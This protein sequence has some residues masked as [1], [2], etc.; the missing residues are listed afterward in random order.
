LRSGAGDESE[1]QLKIMENLVEKYSSFRPH[2]A[3]SVG[4]PE[5][6]LVVSFNLRV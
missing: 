5:K 2:V 1:D 4:Q 6:E 3:G